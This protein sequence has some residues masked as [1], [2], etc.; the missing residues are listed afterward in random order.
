MGNERAYRVFSA[1][2][3]RMQECSALAEVHG[4]LPCPLCDFRIDPSWPVTASLAEL[5]SAKQVVA[6][7]KPPHAP[8]ISTFALPGIE[9]KLPQGRPCLRGEKTHPPRPRKMI[10]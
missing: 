10:K 5:P 7:S 9:T 1:K 6:E 3:T 4:C 8:P 2:I